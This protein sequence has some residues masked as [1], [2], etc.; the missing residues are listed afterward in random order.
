[1]ANKIGVFGGNFTTL[2]FAGINDADKFH[3]R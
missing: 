3:V 2:L 1:M